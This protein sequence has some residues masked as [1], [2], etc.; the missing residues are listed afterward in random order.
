MTGTVMPRLNG[1]PDLEGV[2]AEDG[3]RFLPAFGGVDVGAVGEVVVGSE[4]HGGI[5]PEEA[6]SCHCFWLSG[7]FATG[8]AGNRS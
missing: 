7:M 2:L 4:V 1:I 5:K 6:E 3:P 8:V